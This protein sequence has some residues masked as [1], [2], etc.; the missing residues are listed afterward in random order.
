[1]YVLQ[2]A[3]KHNYYVRIIHTHKVFLFFDVKK[4]KNKT[5]IKS[6][7]YNFVWKR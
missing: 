3:R 5:E 2:T 4:K 7:T 6:Y 1:M